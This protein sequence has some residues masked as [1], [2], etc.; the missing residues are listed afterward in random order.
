MKD[1]IIDIKLQRERLIKGASPVCYCMHTSA[2]V[3]FKQSNWGL[4]M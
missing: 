2:T 4:E 3:G 1:S